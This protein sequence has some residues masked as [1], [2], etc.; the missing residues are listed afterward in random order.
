[1]DYIDFETLYMPCASKSDDMFTE[2]GVNPAALEEVPLAFTTHERADA[3]GE[4][5]K[6]RLPRLP[7]GVYRRPMSVIQIKVAALA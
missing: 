5:W 7:G 2:N 4:D 6:E 1:M 3:Y